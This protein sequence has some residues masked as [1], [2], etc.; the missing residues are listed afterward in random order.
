[1]TFDDLPD[2]WELLPLTDTRLVADV[3]DLFVSMQAR[4]RG[5]LA[6]LLCDGAARLRA[7]V[8][9]DGPD[10]AAPHAQRVD[11]LRRLLS[12][13][14][15][16]DPEAGVVVGIGRAGGLSVTRGD[17]EWAEAVADAARGHLR[18]LGVHVVT[19][20]GSRPVPRAAAA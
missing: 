10:D 5:C 13:I 8:L 20:A 9:V 19:P 16:V 2:G 4:E 15:S 14:A 3:L 6:L 11:L 7:P 17:E 12:G 18:L 1:M